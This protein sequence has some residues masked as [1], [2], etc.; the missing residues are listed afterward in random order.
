MRR[1]ATPL[2][3]PLM[4][5]LYLEVNVIEGWRRFSDWRNI[6]QKLRFY[7]RVKGGLVRLS[8]LL[9]FEYEMP[10]MEGFSGAVLGVGNPLC[11][12][13]PP[14]TVMDK[15]SPKLWTRSW[16]G[17]DNPSSA[18]PGASASPGS[19]IWGARCRKASPP[20][21]GTNKAHIGPE[22]RS[23]LNVNSEG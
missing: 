16:A 10:S 23:E 6:P 20:A 12:N 4:S 13:S 2:A 22:A 8:K 3:L 5:C 9:F 1:C 11:S 19:A 17:V 14:P 18:L 15:P 21:Q 7:F